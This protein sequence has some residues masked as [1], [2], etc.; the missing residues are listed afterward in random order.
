[1]T[2]FFNII[3]KKIISK[4]ELIKVSFRE[5]YFNKKIVFTNGCFDILHLGHIY[6]LNKARS[7]GD[8]LIIG[9]NSDASVKNLKGDMR[10]INQQKARAQLLAALLCTDYITI[11]E[12]DTPLEL[13]KIVRPDILVK[14]G[15]YTPDKIAGADFV[16][17][18][19]GSIQIIPY[20]EGYSTSNIIQKH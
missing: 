4:E 1:M 11:F 18:Y 16:R 7:L 5:H 2:D 14:G 10:P 12:E 13:I 15:D 19:G 17:S 20:L 8:I 3:Q 6:Y 9:L